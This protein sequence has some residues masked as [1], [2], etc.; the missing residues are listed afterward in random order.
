MMDDIYF[1]KPI[2][3]RNLRKHYYGG[4]VPMVV[5]SKGGWHNLKRDT[6][7]VITQHN[8]VPIDYCTHLPHII[9]KWRFLSIWDKYG[10]DKR[11]LQWE[12]LYGAEFFVKRRKVTGRV[13]ARIRKKGNVFTNQTFGN[14]TN[15]GWSPKLREQLKEKFPNPTP[16]EKYGPRFPDI[17]I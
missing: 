1:L 7:K 14:N 10:L 17:K 16:F 2:V 4:R 5:R 12:L 8:K 13:R 15:G 6:A 9:D 3:F 11:V